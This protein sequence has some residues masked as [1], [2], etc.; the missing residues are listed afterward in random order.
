MFWNF[1]CPGRAIDCQV[2]SAAVSNVTKR[3]GASYEPDQDRSR[4]GMPGNDV[5]AWLKVGTAGCEVITVGY[6]AVCSNGT[7]SEIDE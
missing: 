1:N 6:S 5:H 7:Q 2:I 4:I 3:I